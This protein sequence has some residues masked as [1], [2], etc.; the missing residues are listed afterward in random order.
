[1]PSKTKKPTLFHWG[2]YYAE[3]ENEKIVGMRPY[4][5]DKDPSKIANGIINLSLIHI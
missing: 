2:S 4:E 5:N 1:M 3:I